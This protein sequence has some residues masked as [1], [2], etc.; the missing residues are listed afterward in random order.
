MALHHR[1][2]DQRLPFQVTICKARLNITLVL[3]V[4]ANPDSSELFPLYSSVDEKR[5][6]SSREEKDTP[7]PGS[8]SDKISLAGKVET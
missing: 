3:T 2:E 1:D 6:S 7:H 4:A 5:H 8:R